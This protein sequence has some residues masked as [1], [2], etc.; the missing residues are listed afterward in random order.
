MDV[1]LP[2]HGSVASIPVDKQDFNLFDF[3]NSIVYE[4]GEYEYYCS[5]LNNRD[6]TKDVTSF[7]EKS[8]NL[9]EPRNSNRSNSIGDKA[10]LCSDEDPP[11][12]VE[13]ESNEPQVVANN[14]KTPSL[15]SV[16]ART[17]KDDSSAGANLD[18]S[19]T[20]NLSIFSKRINQE[21]HINAG[22]N[23]LPRSDAGIQNL[24]LQNPGTPDGD[25][26][27]K[28]IAAKTMPILDYDQS[29]FSKNT[30][31]QSR[32]NPFGQQDSPA[33]SIFRRT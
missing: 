19:S 26:T 2:K 32:E 8:G 13:R 12:Q 30:N 20:G 24:S 14:P 17:G 21:V 7:M 27:P 18:I 11:R 9:L 6:S 29:N 31:L 1:Q 23:A 4:E 22:K 28:D 16:F 33:G 10:I 3:K 15:G 25:S 5:A